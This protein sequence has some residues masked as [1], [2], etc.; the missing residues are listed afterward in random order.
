MGGSEGGEVTRKIFLSI[1]CLSVIAEKRKKEEIESRDKWIKL[2]WPEGRR[3]W[4]IRLAPLANTPGLTNLRTRPRPPRLLSSAGAQA[5]HQSKGKELL[6]DLHFVWPNIYQCPRKG[7]K[8]KK[9]APLEKDEKNVRGL[10]TGGGVLGRPSGTGT[11]KYKNG[12]VC[13]TAVFAVSLSRSLFPSRMPSFMTHHWGWKWFDTTASPELNTEAW[14]R[15]LDWCGWQCLKGMNWVQH[16]HFRIL[17]SGA[18]YSWP[19]G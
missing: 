13:A 16:C 17:F 3:L 6:H 5:V 15:L 4:V 7:A 18:A 8:R 9:M 2:V 19:A 10:I 1:I 14:T 12:V 11:R